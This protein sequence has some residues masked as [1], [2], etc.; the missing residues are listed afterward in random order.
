MELQFTYK[1][2][3]D[4][5]DGDETLKL[6]VPFPQNYP[7][8]EFKRKNKNIASLS[9]SYNKEKNIVELGAFYV[10]T[11]QID[12]SITSEDKRVTKGLGKKMLCYALRELCEKG[13]INKNYVFSLIA[14]GGK[15]TDECKE[16]VSKLDDSFLDKFLVNYPEDLSNHIRYYGRELTLEEKRELYCKINDNLKLVD[17]YKRYGLEPVMDGSGL[18]VTMIGSVEKALEHCTNL[19]LKGIQ[20]K[21]SISKSKSKKQKSISKSKKQKSISKSKKQKSI[22]KSKNKNK[23]T[24]NV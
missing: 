1:V 6:T 5:E 20:S 18:G 15:Y 14:I 23:S 19:K 17:Y 3:M 21:K 2:E 9:L 13:K 11:N 12:P 8:T 10:Y 16:F 24:K 4:G 7:D 22:S